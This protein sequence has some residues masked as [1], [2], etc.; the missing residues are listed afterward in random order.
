MLR[1]SKRIIEI[2][3]YK[4]PI[5][6]FVHGKNTYVEVIDPKI[7]S[8]NKKAVYKISDLFIINAISQIGIIK[9][10]NLLT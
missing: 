10:R 4:T 2:G 6:E 5:T 3:G 7:S 1:K 8:K 9:K